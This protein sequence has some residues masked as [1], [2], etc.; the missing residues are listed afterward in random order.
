MRDSC[1]RWVPLL[2]LEEFS[3]SVR[4]WFET[5]F[6]APT[7]AQAWPA[8]SQGDHTLVLAPTG[9]GKTLAAFLLA[10]DRVMT[11]PPR[12]DDQ[13]RTRVLYISPLRALAVDVEKNLQSPLR[14][15]K[16]FVLR[17]DGRQAAIYR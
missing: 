4:E 1:R 16:G 10:L 11:R 14:G 12:D 9:S 5:T 8:I 7:P 15:Y 13:R 2:A 3:A 6:A 17:P